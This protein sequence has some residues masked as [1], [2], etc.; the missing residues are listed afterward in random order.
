MNDPVRKA[1]ARQLLPPDELYAALTDGRGNAVFQG[2]VGMTFGLFG[3]VINLIVVLVISIYWSVDRVHFE[4]LWLSLLPSG[5]R[6]WTRDLWRNIE[7]E[8]GS[9]LRS[10][11]VQAVCAGWLLGLGYWAIGLRYPALA[12]LVAGL[13]WLLPWVGV[14][15]AVA[16]LMVL[17]I[18]T[19][20]VDGGG[21][22]WLIAAAATG[23]TIAV[24]VLMEWLIEPRLFNRRRYNGLLVA[25]VVLAMAEQFGLA[26]LLLGPPLAGAIQILLGQ[27]TYRSYPVSAGV[28]EQKVTV[29]NRLEA[30]RAAL[31]AVDAPPPELANLFSRLENL[32]HESESLLPDVDLP[33]SK[34]VARRPAD[35]VNAESKEGL[36]KTPGNGPA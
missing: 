21:S 27:L 4:R 9:Y 6:A 7:S 33:P 34:V 26:G 28:E 17:T 29:R 31:A 30:L 32:A 3:A 25:V 14:F 5:E 1:I 35:E 15:F 2:A 19:A 10:E 36:K 8:V 23:Y 20:V 18:P 22:W 16:G 13:T 24:F 12:A 11:V